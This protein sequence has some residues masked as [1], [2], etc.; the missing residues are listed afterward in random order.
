MFF[1]HAASF[2]KKDKSSAHDQEKHSP[3]RKQAESKDVVSSNL[4]QLVLE[5][6]ASR[7]AITTANLKL[8]AS[9]TLTLMYVPEEELD[10]CVDWLVGNEFIRRQTVASGEHLT[11]TQLGFASFASNLS[12]DTCLVLLNE[13]HKARECLILESDFHLVYQVF[14]FYIFHLNF[15]PY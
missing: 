11:P 3:S 13:L 10:A 1:L 12:P 15:F 7:C 8:Y 6:V 14:F 5:I 4:K 2:S 9:C